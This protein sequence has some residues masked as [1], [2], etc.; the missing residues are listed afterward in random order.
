MQPQLDPAIR[1]EGVASMRT[2]Q[3]VSH[4]LCRILCPIEAML[5]DR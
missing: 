2:A 5:S 1:I 4:V 3:I